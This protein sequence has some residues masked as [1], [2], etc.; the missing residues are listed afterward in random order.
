LRNWTDR[1]IAD[2]DRPLVFSIS[3]DGVQGNVSLH[4]GCGSTITID[5]ETQFLKLAALGV[6]IMFSS[7]DDGSGGTVFGKDTLWD[8]WPGSAPHVVSVGATMF[9]GQDPANGEQ[10][11]TQF[12][13]GG[14]F[15]SRWLAPDFQAESLKGYF[16]TEPAS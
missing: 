10:A 5:L 4:H 16:A 9:G 7:G 12:G 2:A 8:V 11:T 6:S 15:S 14:G 3:Y 13:S 1:A